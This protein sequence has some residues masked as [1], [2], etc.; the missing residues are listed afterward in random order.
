MTVGNCFEIHGRVMLDYKEEDWILVHAEVSGQ[1]KLAG[2]RYAHAWLENGDEVI[3]MAN[4]TTN[5]HPRR[6]YYAVG[7]LSEL[8]GC[9]ARYTAQEAREKM[10]TEGHFGPWELTCEL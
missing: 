9:V 3:D 2:L 6:V 5:V 10:L 7:Q 4:G 8:P 1:R